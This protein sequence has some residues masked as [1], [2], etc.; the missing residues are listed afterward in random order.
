MYTEILRSIAGIHIFP[1]IS[2]VLFIAFFT[3]MLVRVMRLERSQVDRYARLP[4][5]DMGRAQRR[6][7]DAAH[8]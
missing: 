7:D 6:S 1:V 8:A 2:L 3:G 5:E 4:L